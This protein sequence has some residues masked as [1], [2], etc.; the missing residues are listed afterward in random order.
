MVVTE[1]GE[2]SR[3][4]GFLKIR[5]STSKQLS[6]VHTDATTGKRQG[7]G[8]P[9]RGS[10]GLLSSIPV[11]TQGTKKSGLKIAQVNTH[12]ICK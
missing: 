5:D 6:D 2:G 12:H 7:A 3:K 11:P 1:S 9:M 10:K 4:D 8:F